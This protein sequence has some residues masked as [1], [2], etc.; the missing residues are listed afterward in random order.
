M[1][2]VCL[3]ND[4]DHNEF[5]LRKYWHAKKGTRPAFL[6][7]KGVNDAVDVNETISLI[8]ALLRKRGSQI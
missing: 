7:S 5:Q 3:R 4:R 8:A 1:S 6:G 2:R